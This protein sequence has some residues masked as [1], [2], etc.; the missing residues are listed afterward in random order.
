MR[1]VADL[2]LGHVVPVLEV[3]DEVGGVQALEVDE[4]GAA[5]D[6]AAELGVV[7]VHASVEN[8]DPDL[9]ITPRDRLGIGEVDEVGCPGDG[10]LGREL[11]L[12]QRGLPDRELVRVL[13]RLDALQALDQVRGW[14]CVVLE[15]QA[16]GA[17][18]PGPGLVLAPA[19]GRCG[20]VL[21]GDPELEM[22]LIHHPVHARLEALD[23]HRLVVDE[24]LP[25]RDRQV[26]G[27]F[28]PELR[29][30]VVLHVGRPPHS[31]RV[32]C[33]RRQPG[34]GRA[35]QRPCTTPSPVRHRSSATTSPWH[36]QA[37]RGSISRSTPP[38][39]AS[40]TRASP[41]R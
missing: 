20:A 14:R 32:R 23:D 22:G 30:H 36:R 24:R 27:D 6:L 11:R 2:V 35:S 10:G 29:D 38:R 21:P 28:V 13:D 33:P 37:V 17:V 19:R 34:R 12:R 41:S 26:A 7:E 39:H 31:A 40:V 1:A 5:D 18:E 16:V 4:V 25:V 15:D 9:R 3:A 8:A